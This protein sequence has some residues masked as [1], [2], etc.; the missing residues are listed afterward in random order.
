MDILGQ[1]STPNIPNIPVGGVIGGGFGP[2]GGGG[3]VGG[4]YVSPGTSVTLDPN[5]LGDGPFGGALGG[6][7]DQLQRLNL[8]QF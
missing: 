4:G 7:R 5:L 1:A 8:N 3:G 6:L 2:G